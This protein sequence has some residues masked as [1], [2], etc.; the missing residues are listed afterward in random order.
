MLINK[1][2]KCFHGLLEFGRKFNGKKALNKLEFI[3]GRY[4]VLRE[5]C[6]KFGRISS[7]KRTSLYLQSRAGP[8]EKHASRVHNTKL[9]LGPKLQH[10][11]NQKHSNNS[12]I[13]STKN[14][15]Y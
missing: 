15:K 4:H 13:I 12:L 2:F 1:K 9:W 3:S 5:I 10:S 8:A 11:P 7:V 6:Q 14:I